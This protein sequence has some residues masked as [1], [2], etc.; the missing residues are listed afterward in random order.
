MHLFSAILGRGNDSALPH[1]V[2]RIHDSLDVFRID[3][4]SVWRHDNVL[5]ATPIVEPPFAI[6]LAEVSCCQ[7]RVAVTSDAFSTHQDFPV[8]S[9]LY[10][11]AG[12]DL[13]ECSALCVKRMVDGND[14]TGF[15]QTISLNHGIAEIRPKVFQV[16]I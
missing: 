6:H 9:D 7:P 11:L 12:D 1:S 14:R 15:R 3:V 2:D 8:W 13:S 4:Q 10:L 16:R 5:L